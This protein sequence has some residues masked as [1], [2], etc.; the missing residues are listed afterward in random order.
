[1]TVTAVAGAEIA[2]GHHITRVNGYPQ[3]WKCSCGA[4]GRGEPMPGSADLIEALH[5]EAR[6]KRWSE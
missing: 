4:D 5:D 3:L 2:P 1:M 6:W